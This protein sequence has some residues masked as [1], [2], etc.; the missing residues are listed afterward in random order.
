MNR[1]NVALALK[2]YILLA[3]L[4]PCKVKL[5][6]MKFQSRTKTVVCLDNLREKQEYCKNFVDSSQ[7][8]HLLFFPCLA[9][10]KHE[11]F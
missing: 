4:G 5:L 11:L 8:S 9:M 1:K 6:G 3:P 2:I 7:W 10:I